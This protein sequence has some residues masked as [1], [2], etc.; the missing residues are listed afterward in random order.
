VRQIKS[1]VNPRRALPAC[2][3][4]RYPPSRS[5]G[6]REYVRSPAAGSNGILPPGKG[7]IRPFY[8]GNTSFSLSLSFFIVLLVSSPP[9]TRARSIAISIRAPHRRHFKSL[10]RFQRGVTPN[11]F[12]QGGRSEE[13]DVG[14]AS[15]ATSFLI[16]R[17][18]RRAERRNSE[19]RNTRGNNFA[20][21]EDRR[22]PSATL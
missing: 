12:R 6:Y 5:T 14:L 17:P 13:Q 15:Q 18:I 3:R 22:F 10:L 11:G 21:H 4:S 8:R 19:R 7:E 20:S 9:G 2:A 16:K 1:K